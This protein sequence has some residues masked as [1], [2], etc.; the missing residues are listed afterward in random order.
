ML[1]LERIA[2]TA[3]TKGL[4][5]IALTD[6]DT[7]DGAK[8]LSRIFPTIVGEEISCDEGDIIGLFLNET[9]PR[10][11]VEEV[12]DRIRSQGGI[13]VVPHPFDSMRSEAVM[14]EEICAKGDAIE[15]FNS[16]VVRAKDNAKAYRIA[17]S[18]GKPKVVGSD[19]HLGIEI[20][21]SWMDI[22]SIGDSHLFMKSL[23]SAGMHT[24]RSPIL[25]HAQTKLLKVKEAF[26]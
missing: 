19:A 11:H 16:R 14:S 18:L 12:I 5:A 4:D 10:G 9:I 3:K 13:V 7:M 22:E 17:E 24:S 26:R 6:H 2:K 25:A 1:G 23:A 21:R 20:G 8:Q 15:V